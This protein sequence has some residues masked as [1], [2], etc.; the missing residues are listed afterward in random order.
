MLQYKLDKK[1]LEILGLELK[2]KPLKFKYK[3]PKYVLDLGGNNGKFA[4]P[5]KTN[6]NYVISFDINRNI[7]YG[8]NNKPLPGIDLIQGNILYLPF[9][10]NVFD[11]VLARAI[12]HHVPD[13]LDLAF[14]EIYRVLAPQGIILIEEPCYHN[15]IAYVV[16][17]A[18]P[19]ESHEANE[20]PLKVSTMINYTKKYFLILEI[21]YF[22]LFS[23]VMPHIIKRF[24]NI[25]KPFLRNLLKIIVNFD[26]YLLKYNFF[27]TFC[28]YIMLVAMK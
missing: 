25:T 1:S 9:K 6:D 11:I 5:L 16:R 14:K 17:K 26:K 23:Y 2:Q 10:D 27:K 12:L 13:K 20:Q 22:W 15:P 18:F 3:H 8:P 24:P 7:M 28:G 21:K 19:T 4:L